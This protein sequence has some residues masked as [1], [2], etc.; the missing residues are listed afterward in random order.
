VTIGHPSDTKR[1]GNRVPRSG[2]M[3]MPGEA[4]RV[5]LGASAGTAPALL[6]GLVDDPSVTVRA[7]LALNPAAPAH[8]NHALVRTLTNACEFCSHANW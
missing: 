1:F 5:R 2:R 3:A 7:A 4:V 8:A 6:R